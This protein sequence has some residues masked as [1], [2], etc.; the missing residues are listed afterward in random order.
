MHACHEHSR[1]RCIIRVCVQVL[2]QV[3]LHRWGTRPT[4]RVGFA[5]RHCFASMSRCLSTPIPL[6]IRP[7]MQLSSRLSGSTNLLLSTARGL[8]S[9]ATYNG[10][11]MLV[12]M[13]TIVVVIDRLARN[14]PVGRPEHARTLGNPSTEPEY[15]ARAR[16]GRAREYHYEWPRP[17]AGVDSASGRSACMEN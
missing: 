8:A 17:R 12:V 7:A 14:V 1:W 2:W 15:W 16:P 13:S 10:S 3:W 6:V 9:L 4:R 11:I 5:R